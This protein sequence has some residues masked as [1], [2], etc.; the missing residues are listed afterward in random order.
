MEEQLTL[1][2]I[3]HVRNGFDEKFGIPRQSGLAQVCSQLVFEKEYSV[4]DAFRSLEEFSHLWLIWGFSLCPAEGWRPTV[5]PPKLGGNRRMG[6]F[7]TRSPFRPNPLGLSSVELV[8]MEFDS[9]KRA[10]LTVRGADLAN[11][12]PIYDVKPYLSYT[13]SHPDARAAWADPALHPVLQ[14]EFSPRALEAYPPALR[15]E[16]THLLAQDPRP[17]YQEDP[18]RRYTMSYAG[19]QISFRVE[20]DC[21]I[22]E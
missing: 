15:E 9:E 3:A 5:R 1:K 7:A 22:V 19:Q 11:G 17:A 14:V 10:V 18:L 16:L 8:S 21:L 4:P 20:G 13:D 6:V 12:T 2:P